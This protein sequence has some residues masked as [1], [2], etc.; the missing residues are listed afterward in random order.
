[1]A[2]DIDV[3]AGLGCLFFVY[4]LLCRVCDGY[5]HDLT[6]AFRRNI[7]IAFARLSSTGNKMKISQTRSTDTLDSRLERKKIK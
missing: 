6:R 3:I 2:A 5:A 1:M 4:W 7:R